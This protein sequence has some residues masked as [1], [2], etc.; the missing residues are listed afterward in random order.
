MDWLAPSKRKPSGYWKIK[1]NVINESKIISRFTA[2][3]FRNH[4]A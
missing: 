2:V 3:P 4:R 1:E